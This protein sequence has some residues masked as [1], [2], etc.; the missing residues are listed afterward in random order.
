MDH[1]EIYNLA[2]EYLSVY[3]DILLVDPIYRLNILVVED[4]QACLTTKDPA[5]KCSWTA[6]L[7]AKLHSDRDDVRLSVLEFL[8]DMMLI[9]LDFSQDTATQSATE[10]IKCR[11][12]NVF[13]ALLPDLDQG[14]E[15][16][17]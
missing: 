14:D 17:G 11:L 13:Q 1:G 6:N 9:E 7:N 2:G 15:N 12:F 4:G 5:A 3:R 10:K 16:E 8:S